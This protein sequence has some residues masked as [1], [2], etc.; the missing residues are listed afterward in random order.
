MEVTQLAIDNGG[1]RSN[2]VQN[3]VS[4]A[5]SRLDAALSQ[6]INLATL[7]TEQIQIALTGEALQGVIHTAIT[8]ALSGEE[9]TSIQA[10]VT[11]A[12]NLAL[13]GGE[14]EGG[15]VLGQIDKAVNGEEGALA[16]IDTATTTAIDEQ[17]IPAA[18]KELRR[19]RQEIGELGGRLLLNI[20]LALG[21]ALTSI[22]DAKDAAITAIGNAK[23]TSS[24]AD[25]PLFQESHRLASGS[26]SG[27]F[28]PRP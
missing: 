8:E 25:N 7:L 9:G 27:R 3:D 26:R 2:Q 13:N 20:L 15:G 16:Q 18:E 28:G 23:P 12:I 4:G 5:I 14:D 6:D 11:E 22:K 10:Q 1:S 21:R 24:G 19:V 17:I